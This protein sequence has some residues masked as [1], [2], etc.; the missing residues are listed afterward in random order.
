MRK[1]IYKCDNCGDEIGDKKHFSFLFS[2][3]YCGVAIP[4][5][6]VGDRW[7]MAENHLNGKFIHLCGLR[8]MKVFFS[9]L[10]AKA[11]RDLIF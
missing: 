3:N 2:N 8:C 6:K 11:K 1:T 4:P 5:E 10:L 7:E 9:N